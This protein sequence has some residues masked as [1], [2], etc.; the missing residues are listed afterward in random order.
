MDAATFRVNL[1]EFTDSTLYPDSQINRWLTLGGLL[2]LAEAWGDLLD[3]GLELY[4][5]HHLA[6]WRRNANVAANGGI[7]GQGGGVVASKSVDTASTSYDTGAATLAGAADWNLTTYGVEFARLARQIGMGAPS[8]I[9]GGATV[10][11]A[12][13]YPLTG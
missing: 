1:P 9:M 8:Q 2:L 7:P 3:H 13:G 4:T 11:P 5:A 6:L 12:V 10:S